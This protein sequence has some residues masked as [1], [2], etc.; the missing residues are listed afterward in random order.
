MF[1]YAVKLSESVT[2]NSNMFQSRQETLGRIAKHRADD[3]KNIVAHQN[4]IYFFAS[5]FALGGAAAQRNNK[6]F[7]L[8]L[9]LGLLALYATYTSFKQRIQPTRCERYVFNTTTSIDPK[10]IVGV[11]PTNLIQHQTLIE[12]ART[13]LRGYI[14]NI[15]MA[16]KNLDVD[17]KSIRGGIKRF[18]DMWFVSEEQRFIFNIAAQESNENYVNEKKYNTKP[19][20]L[21][22]VSDLPMSEVFQSGI[23]ASSPL[24]LHED[25]FDAVDDFVS[26]NSAPS[27]QLRN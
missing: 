16:F 5:V 1:I 15:I 7:Y 22:L 14:E 26:K 21:F 25:F 11:F 3:Q 10:A 23:S 18:G 9:A 13:N 2:N 4:I 19:K 20:I 6:A 8:L 27:R 17:K 12:N 24:D